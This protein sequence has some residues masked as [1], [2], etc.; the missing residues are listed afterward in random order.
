MDK[1]ERSAY[2]AVGTWPLDD[3]VIGLRVF[4]TDQIYKLSPD[5]RVQIIGSSTTCDVVLRTHSGAVAARHAR[6]IRRG[7]RWL[8]Q[9]IAETQGGHVY[10]DRVALRAFPLVPSIEIGIGDGTLV[11]ESE[12]SRRARRG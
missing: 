3:E 5:A 9:A 1:A 4:G 12:R 10:R 8:I 6:L 2:P 11:A 7:S